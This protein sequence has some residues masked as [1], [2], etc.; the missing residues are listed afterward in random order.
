MQE[1]N[2]K[3]KTIRGVGWSAV[4]SVLGQGITF[5][6][7]LVLARL[8]SP[9]EYGLIGIVTIFI[10]VFNSIIDSGFSQAVIRKKDAGNEDFNTMFITNMVLSV[11]LFLVLF[12]CAP[13]IARFFERPELISLARVMGVVLIINALSIT[14]NT[15]LTKRIDFKTKTKA[16]LISAILSGVVGITMAFMGYG[17]WALVGQQI[18]K[19]LAN[20][21][22]LWVFNKWWPN[23]R[24]SKSS[25]QYMWGFGW[26]LL[27]STL[28][29]D[30]WN[31]LYQV[32]VGKFYSPATL[33]Q[34]SR[35]KEYASIFSININS[36]VS[37][38]TFPVLAELQDDKVRLVNAYRRIIKT[39]MFVTAVCM[40]SMG[41]VSE[42]LLYCLI[43]PQWHQA[44]TFLLP[45]CI[46]MSLYPLHA[47]NLNMLKVQGRSDLF[48]KL[49][50]IKKIVAIG[51]ICLGIFVDIYW[52]VA[53]SVVA[54]IISFFLNSHYSGKLLGYSS[55]MQLKD[56]AP[57]YALAFLIALF[58]YFL[59]FLP[60]SYWIILPMQIVLG[61][62]VFFVFCKLTK[63]DEYQELKDMLMPMI[64]RLTKQKVTNKNNK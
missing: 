1:Q 63:M 29:N 64:F 30:I 31:Q 28:L 13:A 43:G 9:S 42:P 24:F 15:V 51:P 54:G 6:V 18:T 62:V 34:Y 44:A 11:V 40:I 3:E 47:I 52:M 59:K 39:T 20:T 26:K 2:L 25:F 10:T 37:R 4:D 22:C 38:V 50:I 48:L 7:G 35:S 60:F 32:V 46:S 61:L 21:I 16:S 56:I 41:A 19:Q 45:I 8:L 14:Q 17:V 12:F 36:I 53:G 55:W 49:E 5:I 23:L 57:S 27:A 58:V 33:G